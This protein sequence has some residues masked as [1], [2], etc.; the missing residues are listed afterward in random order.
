[1]QIFSFRVRVPNNMNCDTLKHE[2]WQ[3]L[4]DLHARV[5][6][7]NPIDNLGSV[8]KSS[9]VLEVK[10]DLSEGTIQAAD[11]ALKKMADN[12]H[13]IYNQHKE[14]LDLIIKYFIRRC[15]DGDGGEQ[16]DDDNGTIVNIN[17]LL[18]KAMEP[19][20]RMIF[21][22]VIGMVYNDM[23][24]SIEYKLTYLPVY[25]SKL[26][27][28][29]TLESWWMETMTVNWNKKRNKQEIHINGKKLQPKSIQTAGKEFSHEIKEKLKGENVQGLPYI[30]IAKSNFVSNTGNNQTEN[31]NKRNNRWTSF[32][33]LWP[34]WVSNLE[35]TRVYNKLEA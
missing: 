3:W 27:Y 35:M 2:L 5:Y 8:W 1:M 10:Y 16:Y 17:T 21:G 32:F 29:G 34:K 15:G 26:A 7:Y 14:K 13:K 11:K 6:K 19:I 24:K 18:N 28:S 31:Q 22:F 20:R 23:K 4:V 33:S 30:V 12:T 9:D 25:A